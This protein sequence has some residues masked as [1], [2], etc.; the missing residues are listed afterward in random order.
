M[1]NGCA[2]APARGPALAGARPGAVIV[3]AEPSLAP[4][5]ERVAGALQIA[6]AV[7]GLTVVPRGDADERAAGDADEALDAAEEQFYALEPAAAAARVRDAIEGMEDGRFGAIDRGVLLRALLLLAQSE[8]ALDHGAEADAALDRALAVDPALALDPARYSPVLR[9]HLE[10]RRATRGES[11]ATL[12]IEGAPGGAAVWIDG[13]A[14]PGASDAVRLPPG[15]HVLRVEAAG[16]EPLTQA[17]EVGAAGAL[18][19]V[20][21]ERTPRS[22]GAIAGPPGFS[23]AEAASSAIA[24]RH[25]SAWVLDATPSGGAVMYRLFRPEEDAAVEQAFAVGTSPA[26]VARA[27]LVTLDEHLAERLE[28]ARARRRRRAI[29]WA[30]GAAAAVA[31]AAVLGTR[32]RSEH[33]T[34]W[35]GTGSIE[36]PE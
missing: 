35:R 29:G 20:E 22:V 19:R 21:L 14:R 32:L 23:L 34:Q 6:L 12:R 11:V 16:Y 27:L 30:T 1:A 26:E 2:H 10:A 13:E 15:R 33:P 28:A 24:E 7:R 4:E 9:E 8:L 18:T 17:V 5:V 36:A 3:R 25:W 31:G